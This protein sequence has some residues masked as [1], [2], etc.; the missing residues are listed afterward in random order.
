[1]PV[2]ETP[3]LKWSIYEHNHSIKYGAWL[4]LNYNTPTLRNI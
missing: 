3:K 1:M 2:F 4:K